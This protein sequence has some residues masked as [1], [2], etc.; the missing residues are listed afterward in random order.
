MQ[1]DLEELI[2]LQGATHANHS[3][4]QVGDK[5]KKMNV[6]S[7][8][9]CYELSK[10]ANHDTFWL[11][12]LLVMSQWA[13]TKCLLTWKIKD[14]PQGRLLYQLVPKTHHIDETE[15]GSSDSLLP[16]PT[17]Q[18]IEHPEVTLTK[19]NRRLSKD[20]KSSHS[21]NLADTMK[22]W[23]TPRTTGGSRPNGKG[24]KVLEEEVKI[25][26]GLRQR[27]KKL[28]E[29]MW[30]TP[31]AMDTK[32]DGLKHA[33]K[34]LQGK[35][36]RASGQPIQKTLSDKVMMDLIMENPELMEIYQDH[37]IEERP[38]L[39]K[40]EEFVNYL[41]TQTTIK[42]LAANTNIKRTTIEH[43]FRKDKK[44]FSYPSIED[45]QQI[46]PLLKTIQFDQEMTTIQTKEWKTKN[47]MWP[48]PTASDVEG[49]IAKDVQIAN[50]RF[51]RQNE[52]GEKWGVKLRDAVNHTEEKKLWSTPTASDQYQ[53]FMKKNNKGIP[54]DI[55]KGNLRGEVKLWPTPNASE[56]RQGYQDRTKGK[57]GTQKSLSTEII[58]SEGGRQATVGQLN[59]E[60][61]TWLMG[62]PEGYL[63]ISTEN[64]NTSQEL[65]KE[66]KTEPKS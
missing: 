6:I 60:W 1:V 21:L 31:T 58:D 25:S 40:Q 39:P 36:H 55:A 37:Q 52:K 30:P 54:H 61:V 35:T 13:S 51:F 28:T 62:Y 29:Q 22:L 42:E 38:Y 14:T 8:Q 23:P 34:I 44:G 17:T 50:G 47:Q 32:E 24:G 3:A 27:G 4:K 57:L 64:Q 66:K 16:T 19:N 20:G 10:V 5:A 15:F 7:G 59:S 11:K 49:G 48:T 65:P 63:D 46:K 18:E 26:V 56:A 9:K 12:M 45:W 2:L 43:W 41:R 53:A 33:T